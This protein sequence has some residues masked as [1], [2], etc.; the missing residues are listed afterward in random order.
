MLFLTVNFGHIHR[1]NIIS[2][3]VTENGREESFKKLLK[4][5]PLLKVLRVQAYRNIYSGIGMAP[6][7]TW[8]PISVC[9]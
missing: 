9:A 3:L 5:Q 1:Q 2:L 8:K 6:K 4:I 7:P